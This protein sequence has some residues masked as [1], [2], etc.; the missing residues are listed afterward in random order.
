MKFKN[1]FAAVLLCGLA[2]LAF[3]AGC[4]YDV[5]EPVWDRPFTPSATPV[6][7]SV[8]PASV[9]KAGD[10]YI[11]IYGDSLKQGLDTDPTWVYFGSTQVDVLS[12][13]KDSIVIRRP[14]IYIDSCTIK[15][16]PKVATVEAKFG[17]YKIT[18]VI[19]Q[20]GGFL[21][22]A[23]LNCLS[24]DNAGNLY[25]FDSLKV[26]YKFTA[27]T[28]LKTSVCTASRSVTD[29][30][31]GP[32]GNLYYLGNNRIV[33]K[34]DLTTGTA[35]RWVQLPSGKVVKCG[36]YSSN[37]YFYMG[38]LKTDLLA[39][40]FTT[41]ATVKAAGIYTGATEDIVSI[42]VAAGYVYV[43]SRTG[44][45]PVKIS[46]H[47]INADGTVGPKESL[48]DLNDYPDYAADMVSSIAVD[49]NGA[50]YISLDGL[51]PLLIIDPVT[52]KPDA[53]YKGLIQP[54][55]KKAVYGKL[56]YMYLL[57]GN[58]SAAEVWTVYRADMGVNGAQ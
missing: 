10:N 2:S 27:A 14:N 45:L 54:Y 18:K 49:V 20:Y 26:L 44:I 56:N 15:V 19:E 53:F 7:K 21:D 34:V 55:C 23:P 12:I 30:I 39:V 47:L 50:L 46:R 28:G 8:K 52:K 41:P 32:D 17:P 4:T 35:A 1:Q 58:T 38:G 33:D 51:T 13:S 31:F 25:V 5:A 40:N 24:V 6:I 42:H 9:A 11:R 48:L 37:G 29:A 22:N 36:D 57:N 3:I 43:A 16:V